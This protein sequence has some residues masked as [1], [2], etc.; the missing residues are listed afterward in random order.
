M[1]AILTIIIVN[2][3]TR[4]L[5][6]Q[7]LRSLAVPENEH[8]YEVIVVDNGSSDGSVAM[9]REEFSQVRLIENT[10]NAGFARANNQGLGQAAGRYVMFLN[11]DTIVGPGE[12]NR[13]VEYLELHRDTGILGP[14]LV[15]GDGSL[16]LSAFKLPTLLNSI[17]DLTFG[18]F[19]RPFFARLCSRYADYGQPM[20]VGWVSGA[21]LVA[22]KEAMM[23]LGGWDEDYFMYS[24]DVR[25]G[26]RARQQQVKT[27]YYPGARITHL[28]NRSSTDS[29]E[30]IVLI[31]RNRLRLRK[32]L[33][34]PP[35]LGAYVLFAAGM[36]LGRALCYL[37]IYAGRK[38]SGRE[39]TFARQR[40]QTYLRVFALHLEQAGSIFGKDRVAE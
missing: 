7:C 33:F 6:A 34:G 39:A 9:L 5:L 31:Y 10:A 32:E 2:Y 19:E 38:I 18:F 40:L 1:T 11:S 8:L 13:I 17:G 29:R 35:A 30:R 24:E 15:N 3:N 36:A 20:G 16:Q 26:L 28:K 37:L 12:I 27:V 21:C 23:K 22:R 25:M 14:R 4:P